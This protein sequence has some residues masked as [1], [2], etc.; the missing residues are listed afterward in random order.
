M[1]CP[2][3]YPSMRSRVLTA[4]ARGKHMICRGHHL[5]SEESMKYL[6]NTNHGKYYMT[7]QVSAS[8]Q[9]PEITGSGGKINECG[10]GNWGPWGP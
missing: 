2:S 3:K 4:G 10:V 5:C 9:V 6:M 8:V 7:Q 1:S